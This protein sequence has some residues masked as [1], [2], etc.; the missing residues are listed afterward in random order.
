MRAECSEIRAWTRALGERLDRDEPDAILLHYSVFSYSCRGVPLLV[1]PTLAAL[2]R[3]RAPL[4]TVLHEYAYPWGRSGWRGALWALT[5]RVALIE[6]VRASTAVMATTDQRAEGISSR[7]WLPHRPVRVATVFSNL[8]PATIGLS[9]QRSSPVLGLFGYAAE[10]AAMSLTLD[11]IE[12]LRD[13]GQPVRLALLGAPGRLSPAGGRWLD[14]AQARQLEHLLSF[15]GTLV[16]QELSNALAAC[17]VLAFV[18]TIGPTS[19]K[20]TLAASLASGRPVV[21]IDGPDRWPDLVRAEAAHIV[22]PTSHAL[23][24]GIQAVL[25]DESLRAALGAR[26]RAFAEQ[27]MSAVRTAHSVSALVEEVLVQP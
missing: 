23:A 16:P 6:I 26:G 15:S 5:Q 13:R 1:R 10:G 24:D 8:P 7:V 3:S 19:R 14:A 22:A 20:T 25:G 17:D 2:R 27:E 12:Q 18:E 11:A 9:D 21:A 4:I